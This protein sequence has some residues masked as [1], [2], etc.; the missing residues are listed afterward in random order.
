LL[1]GALPGGQRSASWIFV[2]ALH[3]RDE[4]FLDFFEIAFIIIPLLGAGRQAS[5]AAST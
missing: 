2:N 5:S 1:T 3:L 4:F